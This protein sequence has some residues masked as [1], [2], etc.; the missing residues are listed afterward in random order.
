MAEYYYTYGLSLARQGDCGEALQIS[1]LL[2]QGVP[3]DE[4]AVYNAE[5]IIEICQEVANSPIAPQEPEVTATPEGD[6]PPE[7]DMAPEG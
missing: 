4:T 3:N 5:A 6:M 7:G 1:Q 2:V